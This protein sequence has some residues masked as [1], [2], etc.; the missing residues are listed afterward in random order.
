[1]QLWTK[2]LPWRTHSVSLRV[3]RITFFI[4]SILSIPNTLWQTTRSGVPLSRR[5]LSLVSRFFKNARYLPPSLIVCYGFPPES[6]VYLQLSDFSTSDQ[7]LSQFKM[8]FVIFL[9]SILCVLTRLLS[10]LATCYYLS[11]L[12]QTGASSLLMIFHLSC[13]SR[14]YPPNVPHMS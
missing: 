5:S 4:L 6:P 9:S 14:N 1:M 2:Y 8:K 13:H 3:V 7:A 11:D 10:T 12:H